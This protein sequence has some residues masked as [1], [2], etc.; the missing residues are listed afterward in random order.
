MRRQVLRLVDDAEGLR[1][2]PS[3]DEGQRLDHEPV[4]LLEL[5]QP[6]QILRPGGELGTDHVKVVEE[7]LHVRRH[8][9][10]ARA[11][12][13]ADVFVGQR[14]DGPR[15]EDLLV[16]VHLSESR[17]QRQKRLARAC[18]TGDA[19]E[20]HLRVVEHLESEALLHVAGPDAKAHG[21]A[22]VHTVEA[23]G[24]GHIARGHRVSVAFEDE[25]GVRFGAFG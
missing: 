9:V 17:S 16:V 18:A 24:E 13:V 2:T 6:A 7:R 22:L 25:A 3:A 8:L 15:Q 4:A 11:G 21:R 19:D 20:L 14:H 1:E 12:Q 23:L 5:I 10:F